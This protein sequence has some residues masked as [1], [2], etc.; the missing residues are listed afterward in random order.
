MK[1]YRGKA[2]ANRDRPNDFAS[3]LKLF[4]D[5]K[6]LLTALGDYSLSACLL[7]RQAKEV[8][9]LASEIE[10]V[11]LDIELSSPKPEALVV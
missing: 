10:K 1:A 2:G 7:R 6:P 11:L 9:E 4:R 3:K 5:K 8:P